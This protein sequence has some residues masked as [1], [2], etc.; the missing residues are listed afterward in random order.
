M[1]ADGHEQHALQLEHAI[2]VLGDPA[3]DP[4]IALSLIENYWA[5]GFHWIAYGCQQKHGRHKENH[6]QLSRYL[7]DLGEPTIGAAWDRLENR[8][9]GSMYAYHTALDDVQ[10]A[11]DDWQEI[12]TWALT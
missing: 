4:D 8:R 9:Q 5:A 12:R 1:R 2:T 7:R 3:A 6:T 10:Q 11:H